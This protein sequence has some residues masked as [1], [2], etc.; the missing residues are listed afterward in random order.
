[1]LAMKAVRFRFLLVLCLT[2]LSACSDQRD[3]I[4][5]V[6][7]GDEEMNKTM[8][9]A[10]KNLDLFWTERD[11]AGDDFNG[12]LKVYFTD[13]GEEGGEHMWVDVIEHT[14][15]TT[16]GILLSTPGWLKSI[17][18]GDLVSFPDSQVSDWLFVED[19]KAR[20]AYTVKLLRSRMSP[21]E[22]Q[23]HDAASPFRFE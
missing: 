15:N 4:I 22:R 6:S 20:G 19:G 9:L 13:P 14:G 12:L 3:D 21:A 18:P 5:P 1:M 23:E 17:K 2:L 11:K 16:S 8:E 10:R 7:S